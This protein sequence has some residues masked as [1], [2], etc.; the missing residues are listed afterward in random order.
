[1]RLNSRGLYLAGIVLSLVVAC[2]SQTPNTSFRV[3]VIA[4]GVARA[5][6][7]SDHLSVG[8][9]LRSQ[10]VNIPLDPLDK[11]HPSEFTQITDNMEITIIRVRDVQDCQTEVLPYQ[12]KTLDT[13]DLAPGKTQ[14]VQAGVNGTQQICYDVVYEDGIE[15]NRTAG[16]PTVVTQP[17]VE[18]IYRGADRGQIEP[19]PIVGLL[20]YVTGDGQARAVESNSLNDRALPTGG[21]LDGNVFALSLTGRQLLFTRKPDDSNAQTYNQ[22][23]VLLD[24]TDPQAKPIRLTVLDNILTADWKPGEPYT[25]SYST[26]QPRGQDLAPRYQALNDLYIARL[27]SRTGELLQAQVVV[28]SKPTGPF[29]LWGTQ[30]KWSPDGKNIAW[31]QADGA[32]IV[33]MKTGTYKKVF[34]FKVY[35]T[36]LS[37][38]WIWIPTLSWSPVGNLLMTTVHGKPMG[39]EQEEFSPVFDVEIA[40]ANGLFSVPLVSRAGMW[41]APQYSPLVNT[42]PAQGYIAYLK[43]RAPIDS[44]SSEYDLIVADRDGSNARVVF[45][46]KDKPGLRPLDADFGGE[47]AW[48][49]DGRQVALIYQG[50]VWIVDVTSGRANQV[51]VSNNAHHVRWV[52]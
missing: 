14:R 12:T 38:N 19:I 15:K 27:N 29:G 24:T 44:L 6:Q 39:S 23:W 37:R 8:E 30:F 13:P 41:A 22:L 51:T 31:A 4:D 33:D 7:V 46:D 52:K 26:L 18:I 20:A 2:T 50:N 49:P 9:F 34:P 43:A 3:R 16:N 40:E 1:M 25:F 48:S 35:S 10:G 28:K 42:D 32:G 5:Y 17:V 11:V 47:I 36:T 45:P 21:N